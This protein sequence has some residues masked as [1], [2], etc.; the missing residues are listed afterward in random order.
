[1][2][3]W[4]TFMKYDE[5]GMPIEKVWD[6]YE[7][8]DLVDGFK[9]TVDEDGEWDQKTYE[10]MA[11]K[12][13]DT[14]KFMIED[15]RPDYFELVA[16]PEPTEDE[17][18]AQKQESVRRIRNQYLEETDKYM[19][20]DFPIS[21]DERLSYKNYREYLRDY[22]ENDQWWESNPLIYEDW[23]ATI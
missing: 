23:K 8:K 16:I 9:L 21:D 2:I 17:I 1:M 10:K 19:I 3:E 20:L 11:N 22:T 7:D 14:G 18:I 13:N 12:C 15:H 5:H 6:T 4:R